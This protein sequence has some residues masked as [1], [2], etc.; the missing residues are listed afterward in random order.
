MKRFFCL[1]VIMTFLI[2]TGCFVKKLP[3]EPHKTSN[4]WSMRNAKTGSAS[5]Q[6]MLGSMY[7]LGEGVPKDLKKAYAWYKLAANQGDK[8]AQ[9]FVD[10][11]SVL[12]TTDQMEEAQNQ[13][14]TNQSE[15]KNG[16]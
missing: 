8:G 16:N 4:Y 3:V 6:K 10:I 13:F 9:K 1:I 12:L 7:Y 15:I 14:L 2:L 5:A 11:I